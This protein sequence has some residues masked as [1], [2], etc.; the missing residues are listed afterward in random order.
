MVA[1]TANTTQQNH[2]DNTTNHNIP[3]QRGSFSFILVGQGQA[4][5]SKHK[6]QR[7]NNETLGFGWD[8]RTCSM[9]NTTKILIG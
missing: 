1:H 9:C 5:N 3:S 2:K 6:P 7:L 8:G 4:Y